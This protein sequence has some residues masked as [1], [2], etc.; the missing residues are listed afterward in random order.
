MSGRFAEQFEDTRLNGQ[1]PEL[2][3]LLI[4]I[5]LFVV[6]LRLSLEM[7]IDLIGDRELSSL[8]QPVTAFVA[9][10]FGLVAI[11]LAIVMDFSW[12]PETE[13]AGHDASTADDDTAAPDDAVGSDEPDSDADQPDDTGA[14][15]TDD[16]DEGES[17]AS[18]PGGTAADDP[19]A[20]GTTD[21]S[22]TDDEAAADDVSADDQSPTASG[23]GSDESAQV[24]GGDEVAVADE[25]S[26][27][28][29]NTD[30][31]S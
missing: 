18:E 6:G 29:A 15:D 24:D 9:L 8:N 25:D 4:G 13:P 16:T 23:A 1:V 19:A 31:S 17:D 26:E 21:E 11:V 3:V 14:D 28:E 27:S 30:Q 22:A 10:M 20:G 2:L 7:T 5:V 12:H